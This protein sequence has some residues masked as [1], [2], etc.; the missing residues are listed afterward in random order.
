MSGASISKI[1]DNAYKTVGTILG[2]NFNVYRTE[3]YLYPTQ[4]R[5]FIGALKV[6]F[7]VDES[8]KKNPTD[9][10]DT[11]QVYTKSTSLELGDI[12]VSDELKKTYVIIDKAELKPA[13]AVLAPEK[14]DLL[15]PVLSTGDR[16]TT[17]ETI[18]SQVPAAIKTNGTAGSPGALQGTNSTLGASSSQ[19]ELWTWVSPSS[20]VLNDVLQIN[21]NRYL[22]TFVQTDSSGTNLKLKSTKVGV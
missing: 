12:L 9:Q 8:F 5:N 21:G 19:L 15:R 22:V 6:S 7:S 11:Y 20:I 3:N 17:F 10:L 14:F 4:S 13:V 16:K 2:F 18:M 1:L